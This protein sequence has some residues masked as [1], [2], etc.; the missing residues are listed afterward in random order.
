[1]ELQSEHSKT[2]LGRAVHQPDSQVI[3]VNR[4]NW[5]NCKRFNALTRLCRCLAVWKFTLGLRHLETVDGCSVIHHSGDSLL[6]RIVTSTKLP[7]SVCFSFKTSVRRMVMHH[8]RDEIV[9]EQKARSECSLFNGGDLVICAHPAYGLEQDALYTVLPDKIGAK[10]LIC[11]RRGDGSNIAGERISV[12]NEWRFRK[13]AIIANGPPPTITE[14]E[15]E[16]F[17]LKPEHLE[18]MRKAASA[19]QKD[20]LRRFNAGEEPPVEIQK[21]GLGEWETVIPAPKDEIRTFPTGATRNLDTNKLDYEGFLSPNALQSFA[22]YMHAHRAQADGSIR[23]SD[24]WQKGIPEAVYLKSMFRHFIDLWTIHRGGTAHS[25]EDNHTIDRKEAL[26]ALMFNV[27]GLLH[28][29]T[30]P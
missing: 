23:D 30:K 21:D 26:C 2:E 19:L 10:G 8:T 29:L 1:V 12:H 20:N 18:S 14:N 15:I 7:I 27:Q 9:N 6:T 25:P 16:Q 17:R 3:S 24:N 5:V 22:A 11:V 13:A 4:L 28:E